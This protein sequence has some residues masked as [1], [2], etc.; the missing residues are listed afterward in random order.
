MD[1]QNK[2]WGKCLSFDSGTIANNTDQRDR[3]SIRE[4]N[5]IIYVGKVCAVET[6]CQKVKVQCRETLR[7][8]HIKGPS[9]DQ[10][11]A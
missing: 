7:P 6:K 2:V 9:D 8:F 11:G 3:L 10:G 5:E 1:R 4:Y